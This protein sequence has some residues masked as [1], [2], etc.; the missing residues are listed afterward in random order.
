LLEKGSS[1]K[2][3]KEVAEKAGVSDKLFLRWVNMAY[4]FRLKGVGEEYADLLE[5][6]GFDTVPELKQRNPENLHKKME[7]VNEA[8]KL[9]R[10]VPNLK[11]VTEWIEQAKTL[12]RRVTY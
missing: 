3:R 4:L 2:G 7:E 12:P 5:A 1:P 8:K 10:R 9:V 11:E 6:A